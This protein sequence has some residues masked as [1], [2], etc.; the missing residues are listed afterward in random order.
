MSTSNQ[1]T[2]VGHQPVTRETGNAIGGGEQKKSGGSASK[3]GARGQMNTASYNFEG[4]KP[5]I[6]VV[7]G[8]KHERM[9][10]KVILMILWKR[11]QTISHL[12]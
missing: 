8:L 10:S 1:Q 7:L 11:S 4:A 9:K 5:E 12:I 6:G 2:P 3:G